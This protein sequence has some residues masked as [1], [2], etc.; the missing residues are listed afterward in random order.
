MYLRNF[1]SR[2][3][4][5]FV[6]KFKNTMERMALQ[7]YILNASLPAQF[8]LKYAQTSAKRLQAI[9]GD[10]NPYQCFRNRCELYRIFE[11]V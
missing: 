7:C 3:D 8:R 11:F 9:T 6:I 2:H 10:S 5:N 1:E 4:L